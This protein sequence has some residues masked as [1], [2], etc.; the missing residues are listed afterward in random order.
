M[1]GKYL[2]PKNDVAFKKIF[3]QEKNKD[4]LIELLN[5][6][7]SKQIHTKVMDV[8]FL[9]PIQ[10]PE[11]AA[12]KQ[13]IVDILSKDQDGCQYIIEM[14]VFSQTGFEERAQYYASKAFIAQMGVGQAYE[15]L[16]EVIF[17]AFT[18]FNIFPK[19][20]H[21][22]SEHI[23]LDKKTKEH[24]LDKISFTFV[25]L[26]KFDAQRPRDLSKLSLE[27]K[28]YYFLYHAPEVKPE[29]LK[30]LIGRDKVI[31]KAF[32]ELDRFYWTTE[33]MIHYEQEEK[34]ERDS[35]AILDY[36]EKKGEKKGEKRGIEKR[37][38]EIAKKMLEEGIGMSLIEKLTGMATQ[39]L[40]RLQREMEA[41]K[42]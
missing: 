8:T 37:N 36:A 2:D 34:R 17:L 42:R 32:K 38:M 24:D 4:I 6:V 18:N 14:Q 9:P 39:R 35:R 31:K 7:L 21:Y 20:K 33:E 1:L 5:S 23:T 16:K 40:S 13:S 30:M 22:K 29:E 27:E 11:I 41:Q 10:E 3:G 26:P 28:F 15:T 12:K 19:K 25:N